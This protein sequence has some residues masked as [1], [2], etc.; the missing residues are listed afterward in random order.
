MN[1]DQTRYITYLVRLWPTFAAE[2]RRWRV[3]LENP[4]TGERHVFRDIS[5]LSAFLQERTRGSLLSYN[6]C[7]DPY[8]DDDPVPSAGSGDS[9][10]KASNPDAE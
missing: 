2:Q 9:V 10:P 5:A 8:S 1:P 3:L 6:E 4:R 7:S